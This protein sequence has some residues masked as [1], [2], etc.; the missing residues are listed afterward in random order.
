MPHH[1]I[2][3]WTQH[4]NT[5]LPQ[6]LE[7]I[8]KKAGIA[9]RKASDTES[10]A[11]VSQLAATENEAGPSTKRPKLNSPSGDSMQ[12]VEPITDIGGQKIEEQDFET[13][14]KFFASGGGEDSDDDQVWATL[15]AQVSRKPLPARIITEYL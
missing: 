9:R 13:I 5:K 3:S 10:S 2:Q 14:C 1:S 6:V 12:V 7:S 8:R 15:A 4:V 11:T